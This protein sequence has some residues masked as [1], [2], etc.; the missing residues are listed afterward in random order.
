MS[1]VSQGPGWWQAS[2]GRWYPPHLSSGAEPP[3]PMTEQAHPQPG[4][5]RLAAAPS[6]AS[7]T[8]SGKWTSLPPAQAAAVMAQLLTGH[9]AVITTQSADGLSG[10]VTTKSNPSCIVATILFLIFI[11][12]AII[13]MIAASKTVQDP[14]S[15]MFIADRGGTRMHGNG[16]GRGLAAVVWAADQLPR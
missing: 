3:L 13:Y 6:P 1:D 15:V 8:S 7:A 11:V 14:F 4:W 12:P 10:Y 5:Q 9:G 2:D 16:Q